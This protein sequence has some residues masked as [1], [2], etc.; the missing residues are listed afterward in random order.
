[1]QGVVMKLKRI[2]SVLVAAGAISAAAAGFH[3][4]NATTDAAER[5]PAV[6]SNV[7]ATTSAARLALPSFADIAERYGPAVVNIRVVGDAKTA[8]GPA[9]D[10]ND[11]FFEFYRRFAPPVP[12][13]S[14]P[15][16]G[17]GSGFIVSEDGTILTNAHVVRNANEVTVRLTDRREF[18]AKVVGIDTRTDVAVLKIEATGLPVVKLGDPGKTR[19]GDWVLAIG[20]PF[21]FDNSV[22][23]GV[24]SAK[25]RSLPEEN[26]VPFIQTDVAVNPGN[27]GGPLF[28]ADGEVVGINSQIFSR[29]GGYMGLSFAIPIDVANHVKGE[30]LAHGKVSRGRIGISAQEVDAKLAQA[31]GMERPAGALVAAVEPDSPAAKAGLKPGDVVL[32]FN[33]QKLER[34]ADLP[35]AVAQVK[36]NTDARL[37]VWRD[38]KAQEVKVRLAEMKDKVAEN[39]DPAAG[40]E[41]PRLG[42]A[43]RELTPQERQASGLGSGLIVQN[44]GGAAAQ[45]GIEPGDVL[46][47]L[48]NVPLKSVDQLRD[49]VRKA[50]DRVALLV[51]RDGAQLFV[52]VKLG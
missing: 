42:V 12:P 13:Q 15:Q 10:P 41:Q 48:N 29:T 16:M 2:V 49:L 52:P 32:Q 19:V 24:I 45:A 34:A 1:M 14:Q 50:G 5:A 31:F 47:A 51:Q 3:Y 17:Q 40:A 38:G 22:T 43:A 11:P 6:T 44:V 37:Q 46:L 21:G 27:S 8:A 7:E 33:E 35:L 39:A 4:V 36:P 18:V 20:S 30:I 23:T 28:N 25:G 26:Y 9:M